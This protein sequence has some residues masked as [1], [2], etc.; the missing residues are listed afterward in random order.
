VTDFTVSTRT[1]ADGSSVISMLHPEGTFE[2]VVPEAER[3]AE[4]TRRR[5][6]GMD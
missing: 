4:A 1:Q 5:S 2:F 3:R 6:L